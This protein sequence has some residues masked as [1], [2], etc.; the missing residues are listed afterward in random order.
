MVVIC[1]FWPHDIQMARARGDPGWFTAPPGHVNVATAA[2]ALGVSKTYVQRLLEMTKGPRLVGRR[3]VS[4]S[5][6][7]RVWV[8][9]ESITRYAV[10][11]HN[12]NPASAPVVDPSDVSATDAMVK[13]VLAERDQWRARALRAEAAQIERSLADDL[14]TAAIA[15]KSSAESLLAEHASAFD[16]AAD[17]FTTAARHYR[18]AL[19]TYTLPADAGDLTDD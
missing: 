13:A 2:Q 7:E 4:S 8:S 11:R 1:H 16:D 12:D 14:L 9:E 18:A 6:R 15:A 19:D 10:E 5:G 17:K 3:T